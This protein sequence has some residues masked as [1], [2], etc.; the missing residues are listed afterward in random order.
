VPTEFSFTLLN[1]PGV[2]AEVGSALG[3]TGINIEAV[4]SMSLGE[5][6][7]LH[8]VVDDAESATRELEAYGVTFRRREVLELP[9]RDEPGAL[10]TLADIIAEAG[11]NIDAA[12]LTTRGT[13][14]LAVNDLADVATITRRLGMRA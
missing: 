4:V 3:K 6:A 9:V 13:V 1:T 7:A 5:K 12:Y 8:L 10:G 2:L 14:I 11:G